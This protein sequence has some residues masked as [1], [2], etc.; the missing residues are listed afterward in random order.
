MG[1]KKYNYSRFYA[2]AK[3]KGIDL[4][5]YKEDLVSEFTHGRTTSLREM[6]E[7]EYESMCDCL[8]NDRQQSESREAYFARRR[9]SR[10]AVLNRI[11]R[12]GINTTDFSK[13]DAFCL[14][15]RIAGKPF[16]M[17]TPDELDALIPKLEAM[18]RKPR[19]HR[20]TLTAGT[21]LYVYVRPNQ[22]PS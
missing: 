9:K 8:Q 11:Q 12:L 4:E 3:A 22:M 13:V 2:I 21:P 10:S 19:P 5:L 6:K 1:K 18:L 20:D 14:D 15:K 17:L 16:G 7:S